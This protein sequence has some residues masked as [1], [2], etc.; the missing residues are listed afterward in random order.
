MTATYRMLKA[1]KEV[2]E[3][4]IT[5]KQSEQLLKSSGIIDNKGNVTPKYENVI[6]IK[7]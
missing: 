2:E 3:Q 5:K 1:M 4:G 6:K 7:A